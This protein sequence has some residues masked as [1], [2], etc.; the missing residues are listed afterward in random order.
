MVLPDATSNFPLKVVVPFAPTV[1]FTL[2][3]KTG[4]SEAFPEAL[5]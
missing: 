3:L 1:T 2:I 5:K 4:L